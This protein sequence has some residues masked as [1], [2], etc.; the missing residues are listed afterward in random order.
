VIFDDVRLPPDV[1]RGSHG[2]PEFK[3][4]ILTADS[5]KEW[6]NEK[7]RYPKVRWS[8]SYGID[9]PEVFRAI[10]AFFRARRARARH[11]RFKDWSDYSATNQTLGVGNGTRT[12]FQCI[13][14]YD[15]PVP[16]Q[17][18]IYLPI[19]STLKVYKNG[20]LVSSSLYT[21]GT[22]TGIITFTTA[23]ASGVT[24][25]ADFEFDIIVRFDVDK[26]DVAM[27]WDQA[28]SIN[29]IPIVEYNG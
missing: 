15:G 19:L 6:S 26:I 29:E 28:G 18:T 27:I 12:A 21:L 5:G 16:S 7:W 22:P 9:G 10:L 3:T 23:P 14:V 11:F 13:K 20:V 17:R 8:I 4:I 1:E 25:T 24:V 2:G